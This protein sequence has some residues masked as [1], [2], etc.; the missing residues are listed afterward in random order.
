MKRNAM[1]LVLVAMSG[2]ILLLAPQRTLA[3]VL[4]DFTFDDPNG[5]L[6]AAAAN[7]VNAANLWSEDTTDMDNSSVQNGVYRIQKASAVTPSGFGTNFLDIANVSSG[8][9]WIVAEMAGWHF[10]SLVGP[11]EF[12]STQLEEIRFD[13]LD[14][15]TGTSGSTVTAEVEIERNSGGGVEIHGVALGS[16]GS[17]AAQS[18]SLSQSDPFVVLLALDKDTNVYRIFT[19]DGAG[20]FALLGK[21]KVDSLRNAN[22]VRFVAN[23]S[24][25]GTGEFFDIDRIYLTNMDPIPEPATLSL[26]ALSGLMLCKWRRKCQFA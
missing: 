9:I 7:S 21:A 22:S 24:F 13:F 10:S 16:G 3:A 23:N 2:A 8:K 19:K 20:S 5:T 15:D 6:L 12:D 18:L 1:L 4:E 26:L 17:I 11:N 14:N 25:A